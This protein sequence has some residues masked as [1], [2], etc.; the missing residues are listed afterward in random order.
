MF[1]MD[2]EFLFSIFSI[3][4]NDCLWYGDN[5]PETKEAEVRG[6]SNFVPYFH[7]LSDKIKLTEV[8]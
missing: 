3:C 1:K 7:N 5:F 8:Q 4:L 6:C 2:K